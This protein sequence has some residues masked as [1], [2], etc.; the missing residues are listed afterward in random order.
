MLDEIEVEYSDDAVERG[1][2]NLRFLMFA[3]RN[4]FKGLLMSSWLVG[5][6]S[7]QSQSKLR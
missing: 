4:G 5:L 6:Y 2:V 3:E 1:T 7:N